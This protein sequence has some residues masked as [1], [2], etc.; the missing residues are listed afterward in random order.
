MIIKWTQQAQIYSNLVV[1]AYE[2][3]DAETIP[4]DAYKVILAAFELNVKKFGKFYLL[5]LYYMYIQV[6]TF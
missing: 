1:K 5:F 3:N 4:K 6:P 2:Q